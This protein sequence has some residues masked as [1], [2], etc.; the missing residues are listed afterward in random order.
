MMVSPQAYYRWK[1]RQN[2][3]PDYGHLKLLEQV[4]QIAS[5]SHF[6]YGS[7]RI[8][9]A[10]G[11]SGIS[12]GRC[13]TITLM[14]QA[15]ISARYRKPYKVTTNSTHRNRTYPNLLAQNFKVSQINQVWVSDITYIRTAEGWLYLAV[16]IDLYS[17]KIVGWALSERINASLACSALQQAIDLRR[18]GK[19]L[20]HH[21]DRGRQYASNAYRN[22]LEKYDITGSMSGKGNCYDNAVAESFFATLKNE[23]VW[24]RRYSSRV[25]ARMDIVDYISMYYN[26]KRLH[27]TLGYL[28][29]DRFENRNINYMKIAA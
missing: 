9:A 18:P 25:Q 14:K 22:L 23:R 24:F 5:Q 11:Q 29:P 20:I 26:C 17:R 6:T 2:R 16:V 21:S 13:R 3:L 8:C 28:S 1:V 4:R 10:L 19:G 27:S 7:R 12:V 15:G